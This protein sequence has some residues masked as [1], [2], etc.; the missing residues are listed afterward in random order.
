M[1]AVEQLQNQIG[2]YAEQHKKMEQQ[3]YERKV[4]VQTLSNLLKPSLALSAQHD[5]PPVELLSATLKQPLTT[6]QL[7]L[8]TRLDQLADELASLQATG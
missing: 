4:Q 1:S 5:E 3:L 8:Q 2:D 7:D 6:K